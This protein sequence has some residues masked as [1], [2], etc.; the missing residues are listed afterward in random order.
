MGIFSST[1]IA[2]SSC[3]PF[4]IRIYILFLNKQY[5]LKNTLGYILYTCQKFFGSPFGIL[6]I[7]SYMIEVIDR[8]Y[9]RDIG[10][11]LGE[12]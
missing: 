11:V 7:H 12:C 4:P 8:L 1:F 9:R 6:Y 10:H 5:N 2:F 3:L